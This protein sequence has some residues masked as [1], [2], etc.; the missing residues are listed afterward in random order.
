MSSLRAF[1]KYHPRL[2]GVGVGIG[3]GVEKVAS[4]RPNPIN[5][6]VFTFYDLINLDPGNNCEWTGL[7]NPPFNFS[8]S[9]I[10]GGS[11]GINMI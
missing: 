9:N 10:K 5:L 6:V 3:I 8:M 4:Q 7:L 1:I 2:I 11:G